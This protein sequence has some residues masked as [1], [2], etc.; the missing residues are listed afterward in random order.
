MKTL[1]IL[2]AI[3]TAVV[4]SAS[5][6]TVPK[7]QEQAN[8]IAD[9]QSAT[10]WFRDNVKGLDMQLNKSAG[11]TCYPTIGQYGLVFVGGKHGR[12]VVYDNNHTQ[13]GWGYID[14]VSA[15]LQLGVQ[16]YKMLVVFED[17]ATMQRF[18]QRKLT[19]SAGATIVAGKEGG[20][21]TASFV[22]G[23]A[24]YQGDQTGLMA[25]INVG[26]DYMRYEALDR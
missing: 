12:G 15:G 19:G 3:I 22:N 14:M 10:E 11:Y 17:A 25:G 6:S 26:L 23:I 18:Q 1:T 7:Q 4:L 2:F 20:A 9:S 24:I 13:I 8:V 21:S 5:C 16:G